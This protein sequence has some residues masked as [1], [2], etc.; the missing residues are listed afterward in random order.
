MTAARQYET[1]ELN[2]D[3]AAPAGSEASI[4]LVAEFTHDGKSTA[5]KGFYRGNGK[6]SVRFL[7]EESG[8]YTYRVT[9]EVKAEGSFTAAPSDEK[10]HGV[11]RPDGIH[12]RH[13]DGTWITT[14]GTTV[15][16]LAHQNKALIDETI[17][18]LKYSPFNKV[19]MCVFPKHYNYNHNDPEYYPFEKRS[20]L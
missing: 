15:Y 1:L 4:R 5:V 8:D 10:H 19:R 2:F 13:E 12:I 11:V 6:Y 20:K 17:Q 14:F 7:P 9:G 3:G 18:S 16:A